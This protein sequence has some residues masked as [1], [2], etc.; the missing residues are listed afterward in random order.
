ENQNAFRSACE[1][2]AI[3]FKHGKT[4]VKN[5]GRIFGMG[6]LSLLLIG[7]LFGLVAYFIFTLLPGFFQAFANEIAE[8]ATK[9]KMNIPDFFKDPRGLMIVSAIITG[10]I[11]W[12]I[13]HSVFVRPFV[14]T[15][16]I[17][18]FM[19]AGVKDIPTEADLD[20]LEK[21]A[22]KLGKIRERANQE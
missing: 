18:N 10:V 22:P 7:G 11:F 14:L 19:A 15:G 1:G 5:L 4:L 17:R 2:T 21:K 8:F 3:F 12:G 16:V 20:E 13:L 9:E 6:L